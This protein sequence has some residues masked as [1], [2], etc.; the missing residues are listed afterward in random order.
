MQHNSYFEGKVQ[1]LAVN[2]PEGRATVGV[3]EPGSYTFGTDSEEHMTIVAGSAR[4]KLPGDDWQSFGKGETFIVPPKSSF[5]IEAAA[6]VAYI[7]Y[8]ISPS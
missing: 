7:C 4:V 1:S 5:D 6:D 3:I 2:V 8:Y